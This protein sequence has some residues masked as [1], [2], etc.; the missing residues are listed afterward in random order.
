MTD[1]ACDILVLGRILPAAF[2][3]WRGSSPA[4]AP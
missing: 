2:H 4:A 1:A 3:Y